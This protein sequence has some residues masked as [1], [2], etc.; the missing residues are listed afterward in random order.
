MMKIATF[1]DIE[2]GVETRTRAKPKEL[3]HDYP[4]V[5]ICSYNVQLVFPCRSLV[6]RFGLSF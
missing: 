6:V 2:S 1:M 4:N 3:Y 5:G